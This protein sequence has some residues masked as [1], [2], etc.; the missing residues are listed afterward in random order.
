MT[1]PNRPTI[2]PRS[3]QTTRLRA[4][5]DAQVTV[6]QLGLAGMP[7][8]PGEARRI[9]ER[10]GWLSDRGILTRLGRFA[11]DL[12]LRDCDLCGAETRQPWMNQR[13]EIFCSKYHR[14]HSNE[15]LRE[16]KASTG[17]FAHNAEVPR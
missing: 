2:T 16:F 3:H 13:G 14:A 11:A 12:T 17:R 9:F 5:T 7:L 1:Q 4:L 6:L 15:L 8:A 10:N